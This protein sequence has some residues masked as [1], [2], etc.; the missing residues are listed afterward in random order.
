[1]IKKKGYLLLT[2]LVQNMKYVGKCKPATSGIANIIYFF[3]KQGTLMKRS[4][5]PS[6]SLEQLS[7]SDV[8]FMATYINKRPQ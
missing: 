2:S 5:V 3:T 6:I 7:Q 8:R 4:T 1:M